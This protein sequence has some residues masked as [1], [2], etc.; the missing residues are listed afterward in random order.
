MTVVDQSN[1]RTRALQVM[2]ETAGFAN[3][4]VRVGSLLRDIVD[5]GVLGSVYSIMS[6]GAAAT[7]SGAVNV[8]AINALAASLPAA[9]GVIL[10]PGSPGTTYDISGRIEITKSNTV[11]WAPG[12]AKLRIASATPVAISVGD[13]ETGANLTQSNTLASN[14]LAGS[15]SVTLAAGK[16]ANITAGSWIVILSNAVVPEHDAAVVNKR[17]EFANVYSVATDTLTLAAP[18]RYDYL[19]ADSAQVYVVNWVENFAMVGLGIDGN[20]QTSCAIGVQMSWC[21]KP[22][23]SGVEAIDLQQ[24]FIRFQGCLN[25][26][27]NGL[28]QQNAL[29]NGYNGDSGHFGYMLAEQGLNEGLVASGLHADRV[30]HGYTTGASW[31]SNAG[32]TS[33][34]ITGI[35]VPMNSEIG[36]GVHTNARGA[37]WDTH[38]VG[39]D[40]VFNGLKTLGSMQL[41]F[42]VRSV[43]T[44]FRNCYARDLVGAPLQIGSDA[45]D[46]CVDGGL[47]WQNTNLGTDQEGSTDWTKQSPIVDNSARSYLGKANPNELDNG[48]FDFWDRGTSF[49]ATGA[50]ANRWQMT[51]GAGAAITL[52]RQSHSSAAGSESGR[53]Y[54]RFNRTTAGAAASTLQQFCEAIRETAGQRVVLSFDARASVDGTELQMFLR[55]YFGTTGSPSANVDTATVTRRLSTS[56]VRYHMVVDLASVLGKTFGTDENPALITYFSLPTAAGV[57]FVDFDRV[58]LEVS[59][60][61]TDFVPMPYAVE[62]ERV[63]RWYEKS[64]LD[65][66]SPGTATSVGAVSVVAPIASSIYGRTWVPFVTRKGRVP[67]VTLYST[68]GTVASV[69]N[70]TT[71]PATIAGAVTDSSGAQLNGWYGGANAAISNIGDLIKWQWTAAVTDF[72]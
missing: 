56:W 35:G 65:T 44:R 8:A 36:P 24:R 23:I 51:L 66:V 14:S 33:A 53:Y 2:N 60:V 34:V 30:R 29:S 64:Y 26:R 68:D 55:Q 19:T 32:A 45:Q 20:A 11:L 18:L 42:Q 27:V 28:R 54:L 1:L 39:A 59:R 22:I 61:P 57:V 50:T 67:T 16:G 9:G 43:R 58:K 69:R 40:I 12:G 15:T 38:E 41:G 31:T 52:S 6:A 25:A 49:T 46:T 4:E 10:F 5:S 62:A 17:A 47:D 70:T 13:I 71:G 37:G 48:N 3:S 72:E 21:R 63:R 7:A